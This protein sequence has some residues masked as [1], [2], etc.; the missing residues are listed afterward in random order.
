MVSSSTNLLLKSIP[1]VSAFKTLN[2]GGWIW[3]VQE[4]IK[5]P[6]SNS[7]KYLMF[8]IGLN[9]TINLIKKAA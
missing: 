1:E 6:T 4:K 8:I 2:K 9:R 5:A 3:F 7:T